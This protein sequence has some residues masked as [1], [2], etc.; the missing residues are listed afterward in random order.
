MSN[1][2]EIVS[3]IIPD[4]VSWVL[5]IEFF[6]PTRNEFFLFLG[7]FLAVILTSR[8]PLSFRLSLGFIK[9]PR[10]LCSERQ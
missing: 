9:L 4:D 10:W 7:D 8:Q 6:L 3:S 5:I 1:P 2:I